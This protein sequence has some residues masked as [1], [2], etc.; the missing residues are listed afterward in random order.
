MSTFDNSKWVV[1]FWP[2]NTL[3]EEEVC[4]K[5]RMKSKFYFTIKLL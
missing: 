1:F 3:M 2:L 5:S 4:G